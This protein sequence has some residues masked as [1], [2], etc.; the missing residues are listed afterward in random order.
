MA[1]GAV[2]P[3]P[4]APQAALFDLPPLAPSLVDISRSGIIENARYELL[5]AMDRGGDADRLAWAK[6]WAEAVVNGI[7][8]YADEAFRLQD[9]IDL[10]RDWANAGSD[11]DE[12]ALAT[13]DD[14]LAAAQEAAIAAR[15]KI[16]GQAGPEIVAAAEHIDAVI[17]QLARAAKEVDTL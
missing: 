2:I 9:E 5:R 6:R 7:D 14:A 10:E 16:A 8:D 15:E 1:D 11:A 12:A 13:L 17:K 3:T 4:A